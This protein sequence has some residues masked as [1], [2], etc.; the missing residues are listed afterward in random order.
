MDIKDIKLIVEKE[1]GITVNQIE[2]LKN[3][4]KI[5]ISNKKFCL[6]V[7]KYEFGHFFFILSAIKH[8]QKKEF[9]KIPEII[10]TESGRDYIQLGSGYAYLT[11][12]VNARHCNYE[13]PLDIE[14]A[15]L[16]LAELHIKS[17]EF[18]VT[19]EMKPRIGWLRWI[20]TY[21]T[22]KNEVLDFKHRINNKEKKSQFDEMYL[23]IMDE[24]LKRADRAIENLINSNYVEKMKKEI[25]NRGF[26]HHDYAYHNVL[27]DKHNEV[28]IIDFD[29]CILDTHLHDLSSLLIRRMKYGKWDVKNAKEILEV[30][31]SVNKVEKDDIPIIAAFIEFPQD[32]WQRGIQYY[33]EK[34]PWGED[35]FIK[36]LERYIEDREQKQEFIEQVR[37][38]KLDS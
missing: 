29:Y 14:I 16:K 32:Y 27:I 30:Y 3:I 1:Y 10:K 7:I 26:C 13:N 8:L 5:N 15:A 19:K 31:N 17:T 18:N 33:W 35:F 38:I 12:W 4:Y 34:K 20:E 23:Y 36:K 11:P 25:I 37:K 24:E 28:N 22:R 2:S 9:Y 21:K 6:K